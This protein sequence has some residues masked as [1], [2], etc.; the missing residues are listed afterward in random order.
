MITLALDLGGTTGWALGDRTGRFASGSSEWMGKKE[1]KTQK[2]NGFDRRCD[3]RI[4]AFAKWVGEQISTKSVERI[5]FE[6]VQFAGSTMQAHLWA[7][8]RGAVWV[9]AMVDRGHPVELHCVPVGTLKKFFSGHGGAEK[10]HMAQALLSGPHFPGEFVVGPNRK[11]E[12]DLLEASSGRS[13]D[14][15]EVDALALLAYSQSVDN[16]KIHW[17]YEQI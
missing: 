15:N 7:S 13:V 1:V 10:I 8:Y 3:G 17:S 9:M 4:V 11:G 2:A 6:D 5:V 16:G 12:T 14:D